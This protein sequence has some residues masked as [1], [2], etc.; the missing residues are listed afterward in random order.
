[1]GR[2]GNRTGYKVF[3][4][5]TTIRNPGRNYYFLRVFEDFDGQVM[6]D[7]NLRKYLIE[8]VR[9]GYYRMNIVS[10]T[11]RYKFE[12]D[13]ELDDT[14]IKTSLEMIVRKLKG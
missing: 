10:S 1:M 7:K 6:D 2:A 14:E 8:L 9:K 12:N 11:I 4:F 13:I 3:S 5:N